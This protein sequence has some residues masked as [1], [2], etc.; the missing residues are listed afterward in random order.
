M[1]IEPGQL[2]LIGRIIVGLFS[3][4]RNSPHEAKNAYPLPLVESSACGGGSIH[5]RKKIRLAR[6][7]CFSVYHLG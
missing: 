7:V 6:L 1:Q 3:T 5:N 2:H 4:M